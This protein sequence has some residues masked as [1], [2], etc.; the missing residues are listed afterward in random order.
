[1]EASLNG[2]LGRITLGSAVLTIG[3]AADNQLVVSDSQAS[4]HHAEIR[5]GAQGYI[6]TDLG[7][8]NG[9]FVNEQRLTAQLPRPLNSGDAIRVGG[10]TF[11]YEVA[12]ADQYG[13]MVAASP[14]DWANPG[15]EP[16]VSTNRP[17]PSAPSNPSPSSPNYEAYGGGQPPYPQQP[18]AYSGY[19]APAQ[20]GYPEAPPSAYGGY[21]AGAQPGYPQQPWAP[22]ATQPGQFGQPGFPAYAPPAVQPR[23]RSR[24]ALFVIL[25]VVVLAIIAG[26]GG[27]I[28]ATRSTPQKTLQAF[29]DALKNGDY[30]TA[31]NQ[32]SS[33]AQSRLSEQEFARTTQ[34]GFALLGGLKDCAVGSVTE[35]SDGST[36]TGSITLTFNNG[37]SQSGSGPLIKENGTWKL[38]S[39]Q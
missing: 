31:Y 37:R 16:T 22:P 38:D 25:A 32:L 5:P 23:R 7:S 8:T 20:A 29:C 35:N 15:Y 10:T 36:A 14:G 4:S 27:Y 9:T 33:R 30:Q 17:G 13:A 34:T 21:G 6:L 28:Y 39:S 26:V 12:G 18:L 19:K 3:R 2:T 24:A 1:M 11:T